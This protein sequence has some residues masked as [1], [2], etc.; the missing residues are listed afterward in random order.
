MWNRRFAALDEFPFRRLAA[1]LADAG[2]PP[3]R[4]LVDLSIGEPQHA[5]PPL[6]VEIVLAHV[7]I[8]FK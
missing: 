8:C 2:S 1:M 4:P 3:E 7:C 6:L 5:P